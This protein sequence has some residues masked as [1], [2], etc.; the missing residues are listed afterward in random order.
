[1]YRCD[2]KNEFADFF[3]SLNEKF[4]VNIVKLLNSKNFVNLNA[5]AVPLFRIHIFI[6]M[7]NNQPV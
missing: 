2:T 3:I 4:S 7:I 1:V 5:A 6:M